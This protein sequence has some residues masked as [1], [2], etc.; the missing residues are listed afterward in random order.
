MG[1]LSRQDS[2]KG[3]G[4]SALAI[5]RAKRKQTLRKNWKDWAQIGLVI[6]VLTSLSVTELVLWGGSY[7]LATGFSLGVAVVVAFVGWEVGGDVHNLVWL[8]G[9]IGEQQTEELLEELDDSWE[10]IHDIS[11]KYG[12]NW[13]HVLVGPAGVFLLDTKRLNRTSKVENAALRSG[14]T[15]YPAEDFSKAARALSYTLAE[16]AGKHWIN[17]VVVIWG[18]FPQKHVEEEDVVYLQSDELLGWLSEQRG[19]LSERE[20]K[21]ITRAVRELKEAS[22]NTNPA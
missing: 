1:L 2:S 19:R 18:D 11:R 10:C 8:W 12:G 9:S 17:A 3:A 21:N 15:T 20:R 6:F 4:E 16:R 22:R 7:Q 5:F 14:R 13:D